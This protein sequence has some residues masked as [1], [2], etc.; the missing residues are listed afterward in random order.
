MACRRRLRN[1]AYTTGIIG[2]SVEPGNVVQPGKE[3]MALAPAGET[4][5]VV[6]MDERHLAELAVGQKALASADA[7]PGERFAAE[8]VYINPGV[9][10]TR[11]S[12]EVKL[13]VSDPPKFLRQDMTVSVDIEVARRADTVVVPTETVRDA[14]GPQPWVLAIRGHRA[15][16]QPVRLGMRGDHSTEVLEGVAPGD[17][18]IPATN[19]LVR[20]GVR[21]RGVAPASSAK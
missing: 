18:L 15:E 16:R 14:S 17:E 2:R 8:L 9:D 13:K 19:G 1:G 5:I 7:F 12:V 4:Q 11:G 20:P 21:V 6:Q 3:L 10:A